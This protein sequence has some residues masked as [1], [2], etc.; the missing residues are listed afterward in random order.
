MSPLNDHHQRHILHGFLSIHKRMAE[1]EAL[2]VQSG[3]PSPFSQSVR[4][5]SPTE[6]RV[7]QDHF[8]RIRSA[9]VA[10][11]DDL[12]IPLEVRQDERAVGLRDEPDD[13][14]DR[15]GRHGA[16]AVGRLRSP[17]TQPA[18]RRSPESRTISRGC[19][20]A[21]AP[22]SAK[23]SAATSR[24]AS[25]VWTRPGQAWTRSRRW[26]GSSRAGSSSSIAPPSR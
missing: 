25:P 23:V 15:R 9:M 24:L 12:G 6:C 14:P 5:L 1:L 16:E 17:R 13:A 10:H 7:V 20:I 8:V 19:S 26:S 18:R 2:I 11:L 3:T 22:T 21:F 4:D